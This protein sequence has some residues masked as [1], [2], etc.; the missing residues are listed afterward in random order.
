MS[1]IWPIAS[2]VPSTM[3]IATSC[4]ICARVANRDVTVMHVPSAVACR[5]TLARVVGMSGLGV[6]ASRR[7]GVVGEAVLELE[8]ARLVDGQEA[9]P[10]VSL[11]A[12]GP[13]HVVAG[14]PVDDDVVLYEGCRPG[15]RA[16]P[17]LELARVEPDLPC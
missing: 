17:P 15:G 4:S 11:L 12:V 6:P 9:P 14:A 10:P 16:P 7:P 1:S 3:P 13:G 8:R 2:V 5:S